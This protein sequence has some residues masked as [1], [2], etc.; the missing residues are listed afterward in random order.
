MECT[1]SETPETTRRGY[2]INQVA[3]QVFSIST[4]YFTLLR[5]TSMLFF[6]PMC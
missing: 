4:I 5:V 1:W 2:E 3:A 6:D